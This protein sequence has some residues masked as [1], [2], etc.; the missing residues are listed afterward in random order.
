[1]TPW[2]WDDQ[3]DGGELTGGELAEDPAKLVEIYFNNIDNALGTF[4]RAYGVNGYL[5]IDD[6]GADY[7]DLQAPYYRP[8]KVGSGDADFHGNGPAVDMRTT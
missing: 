4:G 3:N 6:S 7:V 8:P 1:M 5:E 2:K